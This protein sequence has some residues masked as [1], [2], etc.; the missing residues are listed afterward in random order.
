M[1][2][3]LD[4][5]LPQAPRNLPAL[6][7]AV[8]ERARAGGHVIFYPTHVALIAAKS[9]QFQLRFSPA[10]A[11]KPINPRRHEH[12]ET[13]LPYNPFADP[14]PEL[15]I[16]RIG[17]TT[18][19]HTH[20][21]VLNKFA[22][23]PEH[24]ILTTKEF[25]PQ[26]HV[27]EQ[28]DLA[29][30]YSCILAYQRAAAADGNDPGNGEVFAYFN[31]GPH[32]G[33]S[34]PHRHI[35]FLPVARMRDGLSADEQRRW[36]VLA[37]CLDE[38]DAPLA[39][40]TFRTAISNSMTAAQLHER[41]LSL[42]RQAAG[43]V[44]AFRHECDDGDEWIPCAGEEALISYNVGMTARSMVV[45]PRLSEGAVL[46][47]QGDG[48]GDDVVVA[49]LALNGTVLAGTVLVKDEREW[50]A[51]RADEGALGRMLGGIGVPRTSAVE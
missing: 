5:M 41:Y 20:N 8:F 50:E 17:E 6:V 35:Q 33:A 19:T 1:D 2:A 48:D 27:L 16:G 15:L 22:I 18:H 45:C 29:A 49:T 30:T 4:T 9:V 31:S 40:Q 36:A 10:L 25:A 3:T 28:E 12:D 26:T 39:F 14:D 38:D 37:D 34:Q 24:F 47:R 42:L 21:L 44:A 11:S 7:K 23:V 13:T 46:V 43:A 32:S 51:L